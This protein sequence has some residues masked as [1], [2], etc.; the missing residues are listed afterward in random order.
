MQKPYTTKVVTLGV[1]QRA[2]V[3]VTA[4]AGK[5]D[6]AYWMRSNIST[7]CSFAKQPLALAAIYY[8]KANTKKS[9]T[10]TAWDIPDPGSCANDDLFTTEPYYSISADDASTTR[11][12]DIN[13]YTNETGSLLWSLGGRTFR[14]NYNDPVL[15]QANNGNFTFPDIYNVF[16]FGSNNTI[17]VVV[18]NPGPASHPM[19]LHGHNMQIL[20]EGPGSWDGS[21][22][23]RSNPQRR[24]VQ[25]VRAG[26]HLAWQI[27][28]DN[29]GVW[30]FH[31]HIAWHVSGGL[32]ANILERPD[33]IKNNMQIPSTLAQTCTEWNAYTSKNVVDEVDSG[34]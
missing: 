21:I 5:S 11:N 29:P 31:C 12:M 8:E 9:P 18:N 30:P 14:A 1:G 27:T 22:V 19:H 20:S 15:L 6:S 32:Y 13:S 3:L 7:V 17:R 10:S 2:D 25:L 4:N 23:R 24:D 34:V 33:D 26:G 28:T 16:N